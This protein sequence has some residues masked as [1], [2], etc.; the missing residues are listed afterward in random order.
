MRIAPY[1]LRYA[2]CRHPDTGN[3]ACRDCLVALAAWLVTRNR[4]ATAHRH[5]VEGHGSGIPLGGPMPYTT[6]DVEEPRRLWLHS[7]AYWHGGQRG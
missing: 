2:R 5:T 1:C 7:P 3:R 4:K 6:A